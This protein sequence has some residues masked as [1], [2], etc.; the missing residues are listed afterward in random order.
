MLPPHGS[1]VGSGGGNTTNNKLFLTAATI[2]NSRQQ[3]KTKE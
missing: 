3:I 2:A 1:N